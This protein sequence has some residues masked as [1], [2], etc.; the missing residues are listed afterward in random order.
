MVAHGVSA[1]SY[2]DLSA[3]TDRDLYYLVRAENSESCS[4]GPHNGGVVDANSSYPHVTEST[5]RP[6]PAAIGA[7]R[8]SMINDAHLRLSWEAVTG[9]SSYRIYRSETPQPGGFVLLAETSQLFYEDL[10]QGGNANTYYYT[11]RGVNPCGQE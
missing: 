7:L 6:P 11:V 8:A 3:P 10:S 5:S 2:N 9:A 4:S 1:L